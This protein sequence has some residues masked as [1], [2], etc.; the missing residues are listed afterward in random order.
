M[1]VFVAGAVDNFSATDEGFVSSFEV[2][3]DDL[4][5]VS[6]LYELLF[7]RERHVLLLPLLVLNSLMCSI[8]LDAGCF[9]NANLLAKRMPGEMENDSL[10]RLTIAEMPRFGKGRY[11]EE[12]EV[13]SDL[14]GICGSVNGAVFASNTLTKGSAATTSFR[15]ALE[16]KGVAVDHGLAHA[17][18][19]TLLQ[20]ITC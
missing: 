5:S 1:K 15:Q 8:M 14:P 9:E 10:G 7:R 3:R 16:M 6:L 11:R 2:L 4:D 20:L 12:E 13:V 19:I 18:I 17:L